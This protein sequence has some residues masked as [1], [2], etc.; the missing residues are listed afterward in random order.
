MRIQLPFKFQTVVE[1]ERHKN[2][3]KCL[4]NA[5]SISLRLP[6]R[7][8]ISAFI[9]CNITTHDDLVFAKG[10]FIVGAE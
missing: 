2:K 10:L 8:V 3:L 7:V 9:Y 5:C 6:S 4:E 1:R